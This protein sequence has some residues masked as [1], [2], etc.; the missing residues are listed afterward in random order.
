MLFPRGPLVPICISVASFEVHIMF[1][2]LVNRRM[3]GK[4]EDIMPPV[5]S[6]A[7]QRHKK[8]KKLD[9]CRKID[10][11][12]WRP[13]CICSFFPIL[14][15]INVL[16]III[17][18]IIIIIIIQ[19]IVR[20]VVRSFPTFCPP[21]TP[22]Q[23]LGDISPQFLYGS[24]S[25]VYHSPDAL[26]VVLHQ[27]HLNHELV[28]RRHLM[29]TCAIYITRSLEYGQLLN[30]I[31]LI[32]TRHRES[33]IF[34]CDVSRRHHSSHRASASLDH[35]RLLPLSSRPFYRLTLNS[36][37]CR[38]SLIIDLIVAPPLDDR[39]PTHFLKR[40]PYFFPTF[41][42]DVGEYSLL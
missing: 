11:K 4:P 2:S 7:W 18:V 6:L 14:C 39:L 15:Y 34:L 29:C 24:A 27:H 19:I 37:L 30:T 3:D 32:I 20:S 35:T 41:P 31:K 9:T 38:M 23:K 36:D 25:P 5:A 16:N 17:I 12:N 26:S 28:P 40:N 10:C 13:A 33:I 22:Y 21:L 1:T 42:K 8:I